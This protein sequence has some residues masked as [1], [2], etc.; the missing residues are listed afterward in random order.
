MRI[1]YHIYM[2]ATHVFIKAT[3]QQIQISIW[4]L[5]WKFNSEFISRACLFLILKVDI[6]TPHPHS[7]HNFQY[8]N[9][10]CLSILCH[11]VWWIRVWNEL[12]A[13]IAATWTACHSV[14]TLSNSHRAVVTTVLCFGTLSLSCVHFASLVTRYLSTMKC[15][16][17][18]TYRYVHLTYT[19]EQ[20][21]GRSDG[22][23]V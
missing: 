20:R 2:L 14:Q 11:Y 10:Q 15:G 4:I 23:A 12:S 19:I 9:K 7:I 13:A 3:R 1:L 18:D 6:H 22:C 16:P 21:I 8:T 5:V 17:D